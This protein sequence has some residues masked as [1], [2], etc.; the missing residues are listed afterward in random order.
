MRK[1]RRL[2]MGLL[3]LLLAGFL[4]LNSG[5]LA[6]GSKA[7]YESDSSDVGCASSVTGCVRGT[8]HMTSPR[9]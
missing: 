9:D 1:L 8:Q 4:W 2:S 6:E 7:D 3:A 5:A